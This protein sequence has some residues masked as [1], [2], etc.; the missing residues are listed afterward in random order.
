MKHQHPWQARLIVA[1]IMLILAFLGMVVTDI[2]TTGGFDY[3]K[4]IVPV[5]ALLALWLSWYSRRQ[6]KDILSPTTLWH[7]LLHWIGLGL[8]V[9]LVSFFVDLGSLSRFNAGL[10]NLTLLALTVYLAGIYI[11]S[12]FLFIGLIIGLFA[13]LAAFLVQYLY[14]ISIPLLM[15][16]ILIIFLWVWISHRK[17]TTK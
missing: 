10:V 6:N 8:S 9:F 15:G 4:W 2:R 13:M 5:Y 11:E 12:T 17:T 14:A 3:W 7:E 1:I 16:S